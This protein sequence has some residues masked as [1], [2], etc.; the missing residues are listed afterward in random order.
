[1]TAQPASSSLPENGTL[2]LN[3][4]QRIGLFFLFLAVLANAWFN[5]TEKIWTMLYISTHR[6]R[7]SKT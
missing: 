1:M 5:D 6:Q 2:P 7:N 3:R 4:L